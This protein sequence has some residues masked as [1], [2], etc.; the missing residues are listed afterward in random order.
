[1]NARPAVLVALVLVPSVLLAACGGGD[2]PALRVQQGLAAALGG[3]EKGVG[4]GAPARGGSGGD[5]AP[6][7]Q[8]DQTGVTVQGYGS[9]AANADSAILEVYLE[10][11]TPAN[12]ATVT[13]E[14]LQPVVDALIFANVAR[15]DIDLLFGPKYD[16]SGPSP[17]TLRATIRDVAA[18]GGLIDDLNKAAQDLEWL[19]LL[20]TNVLY[21]VSDCSPL[22]RSA[23]EAAVRD[24]RDRGAVFAQAL[25]VG[26]GP[27]VG[28]SHSTY[29]YYGPNPCDPASFPAGPYPSGGG[30]PYVAG[31][32]HEVRLNANV[33]VTFAIQ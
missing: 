14:E 32:P 31:Q 21:T 10:K 11:S 13:E 15:D 22:D 26:L 17:V 1:M 23:L 16:P 3:S 27:V 20:N 6:A 25:G 12:K 2:S 4:P 7:L 5:F 33:S 8:Q 28:A 24:A 9:A 19:R 18:L 29:S 30:Q